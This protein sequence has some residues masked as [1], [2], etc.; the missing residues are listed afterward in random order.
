MFITAQPDKIHPAQ[1]SRAKD[2]RLRFPNHLRPEPYALAFPTSRIFRFTYL[3]GQTALEKYAASAE[4]APFKDFYAKKLEGNGGILKIYKGD[5]PSA[6]F[7]ATS[8]GHWQNIVAYVLNDLPEILPASGFIGGAEPGEDDFHVGAWLTRVAWICGA[9][10]DAEGYKALE[11]ELKVPVPEKVASYW[12]A[13][14]ARPSW[15]K[16][17]SE[18]LH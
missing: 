2:S 9:T 6:D 1:R 13:W 5:V 8:T 10:N 12:K 18:T 4:G 11:K 14:H 3:T 15:Q 17:Y 7:F 16:V